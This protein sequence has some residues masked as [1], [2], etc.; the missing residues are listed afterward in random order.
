MK[1]SKP[2]PNAY[3]K[4]DTKWHDKIVQYLENK[5]SV[6]AFHKRYGYSRRALIEANISRIKRCI[7]STRLTQKV[8]SQKKE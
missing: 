8:S 3:E 6:Y 5:G 4:D 7:S 2:S 1:K